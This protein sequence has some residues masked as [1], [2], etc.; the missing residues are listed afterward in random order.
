M[1]MYVQQPFD[2]VSL[3]TIG[4]L[5]S[6][7]G[8]TTILVIVDASSGWVEIIPLVANNA[9]CSAL[10]FISEWVCRFGV[11]KAFMSDNGTEFLNAFIDELLC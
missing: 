9:V 4:P 6:S 3:D 7:D 5:P 8:Y 2:R 11:P 1:P 10:A